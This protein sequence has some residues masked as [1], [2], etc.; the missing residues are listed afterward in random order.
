MNRKR[1]LI[2]FVVIVLLM[3]FLVG[4]HLLSGYYYEKSKSKLFKMYDE[5]KLGITKEEAREFYERNRVFGMSISTNKFKNNSVMIDINFIMKILGSSRG[6]WCLILDFENNRLICAQIVDA[7][8]EGGDKT[9]RI[10]NDGIIYEQNLINPTKN[11]NW[12]SIGK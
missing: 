2:F 7:S 8:G 11:T 12:V 4:C 9:R 3:S 1:I 5:I 6:C 10:G